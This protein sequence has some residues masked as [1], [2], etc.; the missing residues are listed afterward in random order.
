MSALKEQV[1]GNHYK[2]MAIQPVEFCHANKLDYFQGVV[3]KY[4]C[5]FRDKNGK[6]DL[7]KI[8]HF[9]KLLIELEYPEEK[10]INLT[11]AQ[12]HRAVGKIVGGEA[13]T[14]VGNT[15]MGKSEFVIRDDHSVKLKAKP[16]VKRK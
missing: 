12:L 10:D 15:A 2:G 8:I 14:I 5:R 16:R 7:E 4:I 11:H 1:G 13:V 9:V 3:V 6:E